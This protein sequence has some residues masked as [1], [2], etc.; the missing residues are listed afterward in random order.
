MDFNLIDINEDNNYYKMEIK[1]REGIKKL[2][3]ARGFKKIDDNSY[4]YFNEVLSSIKHDKLS[5]MNNYDTFDRNIEHRIKSKESKNNINIITF[6]GDKN[7]DILEMSKFEDIGLIDN[8]EKLFNDNIISMPYALSLYEKGA[9]ENIF[10]GI[11]KSYDNFIST[12]NTK[13][14]FC[15][16]PAYVKYKDLDQFL[17]FYSEKNLGTVNGGGQS[18]NAI[19]LYIDFKRS[20]PD[21]FKRTIAMLFKLKKQYMKDGFYPVLYAANVSRPRILNTGSRVI[22]REFLLAFLGFDIIGSSLAFNPRA[23]KMGYTHDNKLLEFSM[24]TFEYSY[25]NKNINKKSYKDKN[26]SEIYSRQSSFLGGLNGEQTKNE[27]K[28]R[29]G[30]EKYIKTY[31]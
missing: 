26:K 13:N 8:F 3:P 25:N 7:T 2:T 5:G 22:A 29:P 15:Y 1:N 17:R 28:K 18:Y 14:I 12:L 31:E 4:P 11:K 23:S 27:L 9:L 16:V 10:D 21:A 19:P 24:E 6:Y 20:N 30:A